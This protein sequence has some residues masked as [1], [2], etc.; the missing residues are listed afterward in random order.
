MS[1]HCVVSF[2]DLDFSELLSFDPSDL[3]SASSSSTT[4]PATDKLLRLEALLDRP[5]DAVVRDCSAVA[6]VLRDL[7]DLVPAGYFFRL[8]A[9]DQLAF[10]RPVMEGARHRITLRGS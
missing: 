1:F 4:A 10:M 8:Y 7:E 2:Q 9:V 3:E 6:D 5:V